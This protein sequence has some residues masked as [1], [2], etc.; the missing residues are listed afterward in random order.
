LRAERL[1]A[2]RSVFYD[3]TGPRGNVV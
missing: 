3:R 2:T 1:L